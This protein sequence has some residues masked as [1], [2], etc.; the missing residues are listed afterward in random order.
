MTKTT[1]GPGRPRRQDTEAVRRALIAAARDHFAQ[2]S[3]KGVS[4]RE[5]ARAAGVNQ[6]MV[7]YYFGDKRGLYEAMLEETIG[8]LIRVLEEA[9]ARGEVARL[10]DL[11]PR[12]AAMLAANPWLPNLIIRE[13]LFGESDF[14]NLFIEKFAARVAG[15]LRRAID[16]GR[17]KGELRDDLDPKFGTLILFSLTIY[18]FVARPIVERAMGIPIDDAFAGRWSEQI[19]Q[20]LAPPKPPPE[21]EDP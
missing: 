9:E 14:R 11:I 13:V 4:V 2:G 18:P 19:L 20:L 10:E 1:T 5:I 16:G 7:S 15:A 21:D 8:P 17:D 6:A 3:F 12:H